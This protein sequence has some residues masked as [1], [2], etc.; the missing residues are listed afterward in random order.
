[1]KRWI[2]R[3]VL[4]LALPGVGMWAITSPRQAPS[5][6]NGAVLYGEY[7]LSCH[8]RAGKGSKDMHTPDLTAPRWQAATSDKA[9]MLIVKQGKKGTAMPAFGST[10]R[11]DQIRATIAYIRSL[12]SQRNAKKPQPSRASSAS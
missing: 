1:M 4:A 3:T 10:L 12:N 8:G 7:C 6:P 11:D 5:K 2:V 9:I